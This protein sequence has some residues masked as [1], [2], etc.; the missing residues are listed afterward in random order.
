VSAIPK[1]W[2]PKQYRIN[3]TI[4]NLLVVSLRISRISG[5]PVQLKELG[6]LG[7]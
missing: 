6:W 7:K 3:W 2:S 5:W 1:E 4:R